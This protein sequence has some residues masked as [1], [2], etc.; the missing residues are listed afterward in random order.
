[1]W[2]FGLIYV[3]IIYTEIPIKQFEICLLNECLND[4]IPY[5]E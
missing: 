2:M 4:E 5:T 1:M 3:N